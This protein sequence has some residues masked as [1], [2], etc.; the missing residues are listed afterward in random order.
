MVFS[1]KVPFLLFFQYGVFV[2]EEKPVGTLACKWQS[3]KSHYFYIMSL[4]QCCN[5]APP[6][7]CL[8]TFILILQWRNIGVLVC[9]LTLCYSVVEA[10]GMLQLY[11]PSCF[12][13]PSVPMPQ[14]EDN[15][16]T[17]VTFIMKERCYRGVN[18][19]PL[20]GCVTRAIVWSFNV[21]NLPLYYLTMCALVQVQVQVLDR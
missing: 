19:L 4:Q 10:H 21:S 2:L 12:Y 15:I 9:D 16:H 13:D 5:K 20:P 18:I 11:F 8:C 1:T 3:L 7:S 17:S 6:S 14:Q